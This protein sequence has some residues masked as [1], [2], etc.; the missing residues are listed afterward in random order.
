MGMKYGIVTWKIVGQFLKT[1]SLELSYNPRI[2]LLCLF[3]TKR[4][5]SRSTQKL[6]HHLCHIVHSSQKV[7][8]E[9]SSTDE[10]LN[11]IY[12]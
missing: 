2:S 5:K 11:K 7:E 6:I 12:Q 3:I 4:K 8:T 9:C 1:L 10:W